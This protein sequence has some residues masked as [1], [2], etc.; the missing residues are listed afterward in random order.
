MHAASS[1]LKTHH[2]NQH[3]PG[4]Q[5]GNGQGAALPAPRWLRR[6]QVGAAAAVHVAEEAVEHEQ[7]KA[8]QAQVQDERP[9]VR[10]RLSPAHAVA[11]QPVGVVGGMLPH[12]QLP[13][14]AADLVAGLAHGDRDELPRH[15]G[16]GGR[17]RRSGGGGGWRLRGVSPGAQL[18]KAPACSAVRAGLQQGQGATGG[19]EAGVQGAESGALTGSAL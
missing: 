1:T 2:V 13:E 11:E 18:K 5:A 7:C 9:A 8:F 10:R 19:E 6:R 15:G 17:R 14:A 3:G 12:R 16:G 4:P